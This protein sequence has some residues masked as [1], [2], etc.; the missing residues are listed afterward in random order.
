MRTGK[1]IHSLIIIWLV[2]FST[3]IVWG[4][5]TSDTNKEG[6]RYEISVSVKEKT[7]TVYKSGNLIES[8][9]VETNI[10][11]PEDYELVYL[12]SDSDENKY[13]FSYGIK[14]TDVFAEKTIEYAKKMHARVQ[15][16]LEDPETDPTEETQKVFNNGVK[17]LE[18]AENLFENGEYLEAYNEA[19]E[20]IRVFGEAYRLAFSKK[21]ETP[22]REAKI[23]DFSKV[24][25]FKAYSDHVSNMIKNMESQGYDT[26]AIRLLMDELEKTLGRA[27]VYYELEDEEAYKEA[28]EQCSDLI[29]DIMTEIK[30]IADENRREKAETFTEKFKERIQNMHKLMDSFR[31]RLGHDR[32]YDTKKRL[33]TIFE[34][35]LLS[36]YNWGEMSTDE[37]ITVLEDF[38]GEIDIVIEDL[39]EDEIETL[40]KSI[41]LLDARS[42]ALNREES[43]LEGRKQIIQERL[44]NNNV[45]LQY[46]F[47]ALQSGN[48]GEALEIAEELDYQKWYSSFYSSKDYDQ[49]WPRWRYPEYE[50]FDFEGWRSRIRDRFNFDE[51]KKEWAPP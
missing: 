46:I 27:L 20:A 22:H 15:G 13:D 47:E 3:S 33:S 18:D 16:I 31:D 6:F 10:L 17:L 48:I 8:G 21:W 25:R 49:V 4:E 45:Q 29:K 36:K 37:L 1:A 26:T 24:E 44:A 5:E 12:F 40:V 23:S 30:L 35:S 28:I 50:E 11:V 51:Y 19:V 41:Y 9:S 39:D 7:V 43:L 38:V 42:K 14:K 34:N 2:F 32:I